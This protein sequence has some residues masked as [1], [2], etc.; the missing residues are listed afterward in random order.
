[1][2]RS[3][4]SVAAV[5]LC[6]MLV[7]FGCG[8]SS[9]P[10]GVAGMLP[11]PGFAEGW[12]SEVGVRLYQRDN[13]YEHINGEAELYLPY[14]FVEAAA[15][16][17]DRTGGT[18][19]SV[20]ADV[21]EMG[22]LLD[23]FGL[24]SSYR[25]P[26]KAA[27][28]FG[29]DGFHDKYQL[30]FYQDKYFARLTALGEWDGS[31]DDLLACGRAI[32][33]KL[34]QP[35]TSPP[36]LEMVKID[37]VEPSSVVYLAESVLGYAFFPKGFTANATLDGESARVFV[38]FAGTDPDAVVQKYTDYLKEYGAEPQSMPIPSGECLVVEDPLHRGTVLDTAGS[39]VI[40]A[41]GLA[42]PEQAVPLIERMRAGVL[43]SREGS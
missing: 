23:A 9:A 10:A 29:S 43:A 25:S 30:M 35:A 26:D 42:D 41:T 39:F 22:S 31:A 34:P 36:E 37:G 28:G 6:L 19:G 32:A 40:G 27:P 20:S 13:L 4:N 24:Y 16:T 18:A 33:D 21:Y 8:R 17:Y 38:V 3:R 12:R 7:V 11:V 5:V 14:G 2:N 1:M 15:T